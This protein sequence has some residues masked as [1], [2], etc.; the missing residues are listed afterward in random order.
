MT[1]SPLPSYIIIQI[2]VLQIFTSCLVFFL[3]APSFN[4][5]K[6]TDR[7]VL[8]AGSGTAI[9]LPFSAHPM[10]EITWTYN[11]GSRMPDQKRMREESI[12]GMTCLTLVKAKRSDSGKYNV[13][14]EN[15]HGKT[16]LTTTVVILDKPGAPENFKVVA[17]SEQTVDLRWQPPSDDGGSL[18]SGYVL[19][20]RDPGRSMWH[21]DGT[22]EDTDYIAI[23]LTEGQRYNFR[24]A[25]QNDVGVGEFVELLNP[26]VPKSQYGML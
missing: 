1:S 25:A 10:P 7:I 2:G 15:E 14:I 8:K 9:E 4:V 12:Y 23:G 5:E 19:E 11:K 24:V 20:R 26:V 22:P 17:L 18:I 16:T 6:H 21:K 13:T 3:V